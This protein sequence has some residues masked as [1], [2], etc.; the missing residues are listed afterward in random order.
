MF[1]EVEQQEVVKFEVKRDTTKK[2]AN[3]VVKG[4]REGHVKGQDS[5]QWVI[6]SGRRWWTGEFVGRV[7]QQGVGQEEEEDDE[8]GL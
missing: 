8:F 2:S 3:E 4:G 7:G 6:R 5:G 1:R